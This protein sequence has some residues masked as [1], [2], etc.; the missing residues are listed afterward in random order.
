L[1]Q[2]RVLIALILLAAVGVAA[3]LLPFRDRNASL[4]S[5]TRCTTGVALSVVA[6]PSI[7][8]AID[9]ISNQWVAT[10]PVIDGAC[11][12]VA[13][14]SVGSADE[15]LTLVKAD[16]TPPNV[17]IPASSLWLDRVRDEIAGVDSATNSVWL[18]PPIATSPLVLATTSGRAADVRTAAAAGWKS[19]LSGS[20]PIATSNP[21]TDTGGLAAVTSAQ[22]LIDGDAE[23]PSRQLVNSFVSLAPAAVPNSAAGLATLRK[24]STTAVAVATSEQAMRAATAQAG[25]SPLVTVYPSG[26]AV[27]L[28]WPV[29]QFNPPGGDPA[30][31]NATAALI[32]YFSGPNAQQRLRTAGLR[33]AAGHPLAGT[34]I[35]KTLPRPTVAQQTEATRTWTSAGRTSRTLVVIDLS[36]SMADTIGGDQT[37]I[38]LAAQAELAAIKFF[39][40]SSSLGLWGFSV[41]RAPGA[42]WTVLVPLGP[43]NGRVGATTR[44]AALAAAAR[45]MPSIV[46][47]NTGLYATT[48]AA[49]ESVRTGYDPASVNSVVLVSDGANTDTRRVDLPTLLSRLRSETSATHPVP[50]ITVAVGQ[51]ADIA[52]LDKIAKAT[53]GTA[54]TVTEPD[55]IRNAFLDAIIKAG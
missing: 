44:R 53:G 51:D 43:L 23:T 22:V 42:D 50:V 24:Q 11:P 5:S 19:L 35:V 28:D 3:Y 12:S 52:T 49:Y 14:R 21:A 1:T 7:A 27:G 29:A 54:Y 47:G 17:W 4:S 36:G 38:E 25:S 13:V 37:K 39:P 10:K 31:R 55:E 9:D 2:N 33:D 18:Y 34:P 48:L 32:A 41:D 30:V 8:A 46:A 26:S 15:A 45:T 16:I 20:T 6:D 40:D